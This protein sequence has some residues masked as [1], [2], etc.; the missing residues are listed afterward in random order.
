MII[1]C[2][3]ATTK[4]FGYTREE[5]VGQSVRLLHVDDAAF[6][7]FRRTGDGAIRDKGY[8]RLPAFR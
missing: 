5:V 6:E 4:L 1:D 8:L 3:P 7:Q 2:N